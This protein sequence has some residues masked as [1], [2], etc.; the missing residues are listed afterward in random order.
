MAKRQRPPVIVPNALKPGLQ[1]YAKTYPDEAMARLMK[2]RRELAEQGYPKDV[3]NALI[4]KEA[5]KWGLP[6]P[7]PLE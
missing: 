1:W 7:P 3:L 4:N 2:V 5:D 6:H